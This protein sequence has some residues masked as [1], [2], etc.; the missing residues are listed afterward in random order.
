[1]RGLRQV[2]LAVAMGDNYSQASI[3]GVETNRNGLGS[4]GL[5]QAAEI[6]DVSVDYLLC[7]TDDV[8]S[9]R[10]L[11]E[12]ARGCE[13]ATV[14]MPE[15]AVAVGSGAMSYD[16]TVVRMVA[17]SPEI[18]RDLGV[19]AGNCHL[20]TVRGDSMEP[21]L[22][23]GSMILVDRGSLELR[24]RR[25]YV[26]WTEDGVVVKRM[27]RHEGFGWVLMSDNPLWVP[28]P[29]GEEVQVIGEVR[30]SCRKLPVSGE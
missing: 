10:E 12:L 30:W 25:V 29:M 28:M 3:S 11:S 26:L 20:L 22:S 13:V 16:G 21:G 19:R 8:R 24:D 23:D 18:L 2:D 14:G 15:V 9:A 4:E 17:F 5:V 1:M 6:L 7:L 27:V